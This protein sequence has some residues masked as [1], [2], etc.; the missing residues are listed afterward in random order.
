MEA[1]P[2][3]GALCSMPLGAANQKCVAMPNLLGMLTCKVKMK[4]YRPDNR[5]RQV[6]SSGYDRFQVPSA[7]SCQS[8]FRECRNFRVRGAIDI[9][10]P[11]PG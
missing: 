4:R 3:E 5:D 1:A 2:R 11:W 9:T 10:P 8:T 6:Y 7:K